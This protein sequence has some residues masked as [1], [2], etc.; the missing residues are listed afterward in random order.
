MIQNCR[1]FDGNTISDALSDITVID[2]IVRRIT[3][4]GSLAPEVPEKAIFDA[5]SAIASV[6]FIDTHAHV[7]PLWEGGV[8]PEVSFFPSGITSAADAGSAGCETLASGME[9]LVSCR[10]DIRVFINFSAAGLA[11]LSSFPEYIDPAHA[12]P[13]KFRRLVNRFGDKITGIKIRMGKETVR[14]LGAAPLIKAAEIAHSL[15]RPLMVHTTNPAIPM[16]EICSHLAPGDYLSHAFH[17]HG[18]TILGE[19]GHVLPGVREAKERGVLFDVGD[20]NWHMSLDVLRA[21]MADGIFPDTISTDMTQNN[22]FQ[23]N[24][25]SLPRTMSKIMAAGM[26][27]EDVLRAVT[28]TPGERLGLPA[29]LCEGVQADITLFDLKPLAQTLTDGNGASITAETSFVPLFTM[30]RG[31]PVWCGCTM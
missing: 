23:R 25:V 13:E 26:P 6:G 16:D 30:K 29:I 15:G 5:K 18:M 8:Y 11:T 12:Y 22:Q 17:G 10:A 24:R 4:A 9:A 14:G 31:E 27:C 1:I 3:P 21:A 28:K 2:G 20:A 19:D 7:Y